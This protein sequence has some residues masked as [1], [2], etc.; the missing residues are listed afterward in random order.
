MKQSKREAILFKVDFEKAFDSV[1]WIFLDDIMRQMAI[2]SLGEDG[3][4]I[5]YRQ[6]GHR[7]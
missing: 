5:A 1:C 3:F 6:Q 7:F 4:K 2:S